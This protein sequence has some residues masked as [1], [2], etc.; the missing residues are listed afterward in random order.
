MRPDEFILAGDHPIWDGCVFAGLGQII[1][2]AHYQDSMAQLGFAGSHGL[3]TNMTPASAWQWDAELGRWAT[4]FDYTTS[5]AIVIANPTIRPFAGDGTFNVWVKPIASTSSRPLI[6]QGS[7]AKVNW[8]YVIVNADNTV[9]FSFDDN[10]T[11]L[12]WDTTL[13]VPDDIWSLVSVVK[14]ASGFISYIN[15]TPSGSGAARGDCSSAEDITIGYDQFAGSNHY[16]WGGLSDVMLH[17]RAFT[18]PEIQ[19]LASSDPM[20]GGAILAPHRP[21]PPSAGGTFPSTIQFPTIS[22][23]I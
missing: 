19:L 15:G 2:S 4:E 1:Y 11:R 5:P 12:E 3:L 17:N 7:T 21:S 20:L 23:V 22:L 16:W 13:T 18:L 14:G 8:W 10:T 9:H 6:G